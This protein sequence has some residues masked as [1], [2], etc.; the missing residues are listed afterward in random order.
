MTK[1]TSPKH[2]K[3]MTQM[4][5]IKKLKQFNV[6]QPS[7]GIIGF[8]LVAVL[9][10]GC[11]LYVDYRDVNQRLSYNVV[12]KKLANL[13][14]TEAET[15]YGGDM[16][17]RVGFLDDG[18]EDCDVFDGQWV[19]D[20]SYPLYRSKDCLF[21]D[22]GFRCLENGRPDD[23]FT[24]WRWQPKDCNLPRFDARLMLEKLRNR[25]VVFAGDSI[26]RNQ[27]ESLLCMLTS[28]IPDNSAVYEVNGNPITKHR[29]F[30]NFMFRDYNCTV[31]YYRAPFLVVQGSP[32]K[33]HP[34][35]V[36][37]VLRVDILAWSSKQWK[38]A[39]VLVLNSGH[40][41]TYD[42]TIRNDCYF[43]EGDKVRMNMSVETA[44]ERSL[45]TL[46]DWL[47]SEVNLSKTQ[48]FFRTF[49]PVHFSN[50]DWKSD[51]SC[52]MEREPDL[53]S[54]VSV[55]EYHFNIVSDVLSNY[56][57]KQVTKNVVLLNVTYMTT[58]RKDGH[59]SLY[60]RGPELGPA[61]LHRQ[62][63][64]HWCLP[65]VPDSWNELLYALFLKRESVHF[66]KMAKKASWL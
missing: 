38:D 28:A 48:V 18:G 47:G 61:S 9:L 50:G 62:D 46:L 42:K 22:S 60:N 10:I 8:V 66:L 58:Q 13:P 27:W 40:W 26:A 14:P 19:W 6:L 5:S 1:K 44:Y 33:D 3:T 2:T 37:R 24:K 43:Q 7:Q 34:K 56:S 36:K 23:S 4:D 21:E 35:E 30:L 25:R 63:C 59:P 41:W 15:P 53:A 52:H 32:P 64:S 11:F 29:G 65:G 12:P 49:S 39:D 57:K 54:N 20:D 16:F 31:E 45:E 55:S 51:G 17:Q